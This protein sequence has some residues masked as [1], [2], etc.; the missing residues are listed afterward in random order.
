MPS[1]PVRRQMLE[2]LLPEG[3]AVTRKWLFKRAKLG[4]HAIDNLV[5]SRQ[6]QL[7]QKGIYARGYA[8]LPWQS[9]V[10]TLQSIIPTD[11][12]VG[13]L[14]AL[15]LKGFAHYLPL[16][17]RTVI[18]LYGNDK[19]PAWPEAVS[20]NL[21]LVSHK[22]RELFEDMDTAAANKYNSLHFWK[23]GS[24]LKISCVEKACLEMLNEVPQK[25]S[26]EYAE[27]LMQG[28]TT[29]SPRTMQSLLEQCTSIKV[30]RLFLWM[31]SRQNYN[32]FTKLKTKNIDLGSGN[33]VIVKGGVLD[34]NFKITVPKNF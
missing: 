26:P 1:N 21:T 33:R 4:P 31:A 30:K 12:V 27:Q 34:K 19:C 5:K 32:W 29:L 9:V 7:L 18:H 8:D 20:K 6:L 24:E 23:E 17:K 2:K 28:V 14:T 3:V 11:L 13:G 16:S 10:Y 25:L 15:E 22:R